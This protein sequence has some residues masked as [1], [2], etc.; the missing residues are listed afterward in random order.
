MRPACPDRFNLYI[1]IYFHQ[2][3]VFFTYFVDILQV[4]PAGT[5]GWDINA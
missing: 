3:K 1:Y 4:L 2:N 5:S